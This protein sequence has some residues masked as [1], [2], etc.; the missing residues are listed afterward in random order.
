[1]PAKRFITPLK[2]CECGGSL[3]EGRGKTVS[4]CMYGFNGMEEVTHVTKRCCAKTCQATY[5]YN[6]KWEGGYKVNTRRIRDVE[7]LFV[8]DKTCFAM[9]YLVY[10]EDLQFRGYLSGRAITWA[11]RQSL[12][13]GEDVHSHLHEL[14][15]DA[16]FLRLAMQEYEPLGDAYLHTIKIGQEVTNCVTRLYDAHL[17]EKVFPPRD[18]SSVKEIIADGHEKVLVKL[19]GSRTPSARSGRPRKTARGPTPYGHGWFL[20]ENPKDGRILAASEMHVPENNEI[21]INTMKKALAPLDSVDTAIMDKMCKVMPAAQKDE[22]FADIKYWAVDL[23]HAHKHNKACKC[24]PHVHLRLKRRLARVNTS[25]AEQV[26]SWLRG[27]AKTF[28]EFRPERHYFLMLYYCKRHNQMISEGETSHLNK[29]SYKNAKK[30][31]AKPYH[32]NKKTKASNKKAMKKVIKR[33][34]KK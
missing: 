1:M 14:Y 25:R 10:H 17:H 19:C 24:N 4:A 33:I 27:F 2:K 26:F 13:K 18:K 34:I 32:C 7:A 21:A 29:Y 28:N 8:N 31:Q 11:G 23:F 3:S 16:R 5:A 30:R 20:V 12:F 9:D 15:S 6:F 22:A